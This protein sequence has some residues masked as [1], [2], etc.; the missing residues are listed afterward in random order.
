MLFWPAAQ[1]SP[2]AAVAVALAVVS[3]VALCGCSASPSS[4]PPMRTAPIGAVHP[5]PTTSTTTTTT[6]P[7]LPVTPVQWTTCGDLQCGS[8]TVPLDYARPDG[9]TVQIAVARHPAEDPSERIGSLVINPG[10]PGTSGIDDLPNELSVLTPGLLDRF[11]IVSFDPRGVERSSPVTC[12]GGGSGSGGSGGGGSGQLIDPVPTTPAAQQ[13]L[14]QNDQEFA[15]QCERSSGVI[16]PYVDTADTARDL[17]RIRAA[18]GDAQLTFIGHSYGTLLGA[19]YAELFPTK[20][21][22][23]VLDGAIDPALSTVQYVTEQAESYESDLQAFFAWCAADPGCA[24]HPVGDPTTALLAL[25]QRSRTLPLSA[26][27]GGTAGPGELYDSLLAGLESRS[28]WPSLAG[29]TGRRRVGQRRAGLFDD[30]PLRDGGLVQRGRGRTGNRLPRP[31]GG[32][33]PVEL[34]GPGCAGRA[35]RTGFRSA[36]R[37]GAARLCHLA[38]TGDAHAGAGRRPGGTAD[39][40]GGHHRRPGHPVLVGAVAGQ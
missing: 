28:S 16:L 7:P 25:I 9:P 31:P 38:G 11:D 2:A 1:R 14:L 21:R 12:T 18:L 35:V 10:G 4:A 26:S 5:S 33:Q 27:G 19:T 39:S 8:V 30:R 3:G 34:S 22:A 32:P 29:S 20:V 36:P 23:M 40:G 37:L 6:E 15:A 13:A 24:W 17:D